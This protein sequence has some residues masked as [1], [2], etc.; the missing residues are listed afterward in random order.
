MTGVNLENGAIWG[1]DFNTQIAGT[2]NG[3][4]FSYETTSNSYNLHL[5]G[6]KSYQLVSSGQ[7]AVGTVIGS[8]GRMQL[9]TYG[10]ATSPQATA[11]D[12]VIESGGVMTVYGNSVL[13]GR[14]ELAGSM[15]VTGGRRDRR[16][17]RRHQY[18]SAQANSGSLHLYDNGARLYHRGKL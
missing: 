10:S 18:R 7:T 17:R 1:L 15:T 4:A 5:C 2:S 16:R 3:S 6:G 11:A 13:T 9:G 14:T 8:G 12:T